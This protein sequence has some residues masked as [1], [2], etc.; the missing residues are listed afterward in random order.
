MHTNL[1]VG[2]NGVND[3]LARRLGFIDYQPKEEDVIPDNF[4]R[5]GLIQEQCLI[6]YANFVKKP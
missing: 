3:S 1:D 6:S 5:Y 2:L 4:I